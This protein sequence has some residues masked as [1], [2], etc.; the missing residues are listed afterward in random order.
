MSQTSTTTVTDE[1]ARFRAFT[2]LGV[3]LTGLMGG[4]VFATSFQWLTM[5]AFNE[6]GS[7]QFYWI[8][9]AVGPL[10][11]SIVALYLASTAM[12]TDDTLARPVARASLATSV[13]AAVGALLLMLVTF[14][15]P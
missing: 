4:G 14:D 2:A 15:T 1:A 11:L 7:D 6:N 8:G 3:A 5:R 9:V 13:L 10:L 12:A